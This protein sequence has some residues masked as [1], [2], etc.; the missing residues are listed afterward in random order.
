VLWNGRKCDCHAQQGEVLH[1]HVRGPESQWK[2][3]ITLPLKKMKVVL[4]LRKG[5]KSVT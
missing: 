5:T 4:M 2:I 3:F 1:A